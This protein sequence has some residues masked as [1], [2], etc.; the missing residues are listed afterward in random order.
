MSRAYGIFGKGKKL[1]FRFSSISV[2]GRAIVL[3]HEIQ[4]NCCLF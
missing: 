1:F 2:F 4:D 3:L